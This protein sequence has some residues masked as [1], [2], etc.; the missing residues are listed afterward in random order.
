MSFCAY[1]IGADSECTVEG[2]ESVDVSYPK[3]IGDLKS[4]GAK[5]EV[6]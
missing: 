6:Q 3:F 2:L 5:I 4:L 1:A